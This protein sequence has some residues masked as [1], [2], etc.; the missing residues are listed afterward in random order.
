MEEEEE[1]FRCLS[2]QEVA[3]LVLPLELDESLT[4]EQWTAEHLPFPMDHVVDDAVAVDCGEEVDATAEF[5][6]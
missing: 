3:Y 6:F 2:Q 5:A 4:L 1:A